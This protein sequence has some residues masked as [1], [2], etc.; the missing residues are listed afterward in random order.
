MNHFAP[1]A[2]LDT[3]DLVGSLRNRMA[4]FD[5]I[6]IRQET[7]GSAHTHTRSIFLRGPEN[8]NTQNWFED[9]P[10]IDYQPLAGWKEAIRFSGIL[11]AALTTRLPVQIDPLHRGK[12][13]IVELAP[14]SAVDW[15]RD[16]GAYARVHR[17]FHLPLVTN[18]GCF[19]FSGGE[20]AQLPV[21]ALTWFDNHALHSA[22]NFGQYPRVHLIVDYRI[23]PPATEASAKDTEE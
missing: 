16:E 1:I 18:P 23:A 2:H 13:M 21:G 19:L 10:Q 4:L 11:G 12:A 17:R 7:P 8:P 3:F 9:V 6:K 14:G 5:K 22:V 15:H 20:Y